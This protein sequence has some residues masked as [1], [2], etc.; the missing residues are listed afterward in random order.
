MKLNKDWEQ[1]W[2][3]IEMPQEK[4]NRIIEGAIG[5]APKQRAHSKM[6]KV[7]KRWH[8]LDVR[9]LSRR[10]QVISAVG[11]SAAAL[12]LIALAVNQ[13]QIDTTSY[14]TESANY[15]QHAESPDMNQAAEEAVGEAA[16]GEGATD[17]ANSAVTGDGA[18][19]FKSEEGASGQQDSPQASA[20]QETADAQDAANKTAQFYTYYKQ[21]T[22]FTKDTEALEALIRESGSYI[23]TSDKGKWMGELQ[24]A[25]YTIRIPK[26]GS[27]D[28]LDK[29]KQI[30][31]TTDESVRTENYGV[32][33]SDNESRV[34]ALEAEE[35]ALLEILKKSEKMEDM[36]KIHERLSVVRAEREGLVRANKGIDNKV[37][38]LTVDVTINEVDKTEKKQESP[39]ITNRIQG[40]LEKQKQFWQELGGNLVVSIASNAVY[41]ILAILLLVMLVYGY[42]RKKKKETK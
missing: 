29:L 35:E 37:D 11:I 20:E 32:E 38:Y 10:A 2:Q 7:K 12:L 28:V 18:V 23:E 22:D 39:S 26:T 1:Q 19:A 24:Q 4:V 14:K 15:S 33:Y 42:K 16:T 25:T 31:E 40:N 6:E 8:K 21:S 17:E 36:L 13:A 9:R 5:S 41:I 3:D 30:G 34:K 27:Q